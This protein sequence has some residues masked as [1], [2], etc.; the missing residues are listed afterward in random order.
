MMRI[1][2]LVM[3][4]MIAMAEE[5]PKLPAWIEQDPDSNGAYFR[6]LSPWY[7]SDD[8]SMSRHAE[9]DALKD[10]YHKVAGYFGVQIIASVRVKQKGTET[11]KSTTVQ[12][13]VESRTNQLI[14]KLEPVKSFEEF[15]ADRSNFRTYVLLQ[16]DPESER[17][18]WSIIEADKREF[19]AIKAEVLELIEA[20]SY[21]KAQNRL[22]IAKGMRS[23]TMDDTVASL[24]KRLDELKA[25][26][27]MAKLSVSKQRFLPRETIHAEVSL[28]QQGY[29]YLFYDNGSDVELLFPNEM[30]RNNYLKKEQLVDFPNNDVMLSAYESSLDKNVSIRAV[31]SKK[32]FD[33]FTRSID[34]IDGVHIFASDDRVFDEF[35]HCIDEGECTESVSFL[36]VTN[37][38]AYEALEIT[39]QA[40]EPVKQKIEHALAQRG[41]ISSA[42]NRKLHISLVKQRKYSNLLES[43]IES[44]AIK[45]YFDDG[46]GNNKIVKET[47]SENELTEKIEAIFKSL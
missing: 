38:L 8:A 9:K 12:R 10:A 25:G 14:F 17:Q 23:A 43:W 21:F 42:S 32:R 3:V 35:Q 1:I 37:Q 15:N 4:A 22:D 5:A 30:Q 44:Y 18:I 26:Q 47:A 45:A 41:I 2:W 6:G 27:L 24:Q 19:E 46:A 28:N 7:V 36:S 20:K 34:T 40:E 33:L 11:A 13:D 29:L 31:A 39:I 16:L